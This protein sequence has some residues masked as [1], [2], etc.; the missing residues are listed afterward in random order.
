M[1][2]LLFFFLFDGGQVPIPNRAYYNLEWNWDG[3]EQ[4]MLGKKM[5][6]GWRNKT[7]PVSFPSVDKVICP[8]RMV[9]LSHNANFLFISNESPK[10]RYYAWEIK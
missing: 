1:A 6:G 3:A 8:V 5:N 10:K 7:R 9:L 2:S 4:S